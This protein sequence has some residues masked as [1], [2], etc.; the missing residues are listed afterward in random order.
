MGKTEIRIQF[1][2]ESV[3]IFDYQFHCCTLSIGYSISSY[4]CTEKINNEKNDQGTSII[5]LFRWIEFERAFELRFVEHSSKLWLSYYPFLLSC[6]CEDAVLLLVFK[7]S[8]VDRWWNWWSLLTQRAPKPYYEP[9]R[10]SWH[11]FHDFVTCCFS[12]TYISSLRIIL[13]LAIIE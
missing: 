13:R 9:I 12:Y 7:V 8:I 5:T 10:F 11:W 2:E 4:L 6:S 3:Q 1:H